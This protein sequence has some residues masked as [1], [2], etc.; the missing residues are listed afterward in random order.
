MLYVKKAGI[1]V[2]PKA[3]RP[4]IWR[5]KD[6]GYLARVQATH[7][8]TGKPVSR[9]KSRPT[10][11]DALAW[12]VD[13]RRVIADA[14]EEKPRQRIRFSN[15]AAG[16]LKEKIARGEVNSLATEEVWMS[17]FERH[18]HPFFGQMFLDKIRALDVREWLKGLTG[19]GLAAR[20]INHY[21]GNLKSIFNA[22]VAEELME[23][24]PA[25]HVKQLPVDR[26]RTYTREQPNSLLVDELP[27]LWAF[28]AK[29][30]PRWY[31][32]IVLGTVYGLRPSSLRPLRWRGP[33]SDI[34][35]DEG[36]LLIRQSHSRGQTIMDSTKTGEDLELP[37]APAI[38]DLLRW[39][40]ERY[41]QEGSDL[42]FPG[43]GG[44]LLSRN[45]IA[46]WFH[47]CE[48][49]IGNGKHLTPR[50]MRRSFYNLAARTAA[51]DAMIRS[52]TGHRTPGMADRYRSQLMDSQGSLMAEVVD[53][54]QVRRE[55]GASTDR[56]TTRESGASADRSA[57]AQRRGNG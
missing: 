25:E 36:L 49:E 55:K 37:L 31:A 47:V 38:L 45:T 12:Q 20:T 19:A 48:Q 11:Q 5:R 32:L 4:G 26:C 21:L 56:E 24:N 51:Q 46:Y 40:V 30:K 8:Q 14:G 53:L 43:R 23:K 44:R 54:A 57:S 7:P 18:L 9:I 27:G 50:A 41:A 1:E 15:Y 13:E 17:A 33:S 42:L 3:I 2:E 16:L 39:H 28:L 34:K 35:W 52:I 22:A 6:G 29:K 10:L